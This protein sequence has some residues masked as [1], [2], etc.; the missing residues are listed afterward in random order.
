MSDADKAQGLGEELE[1]VAPLNAACFR[2][3]S[4]SGPSRN[5]MNSIR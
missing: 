4:S 3:I 5:G 2:V 1:L